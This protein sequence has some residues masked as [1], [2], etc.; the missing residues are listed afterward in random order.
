MIAFTL[1]F[2]CN[3]PNSELKSERKISAK[4]V[5]VTKIS[6]IVAKSGEVVH[7]YG[8]NFDTSSRLYRF[9]IPLM[10]GSQKLVRIAVNDSSTASFTMPDGVGLG[11]KTVDFQNNSETISSFN[12]IA[13]Q[14]ANTL[15]IIID[16]ANEICS[17]RKYIDRDGNTSTGTKDCANGSI[18]DC[19]TDGETGCKTTET[20]K[21]ANSSVA[22]AANIKAGVTIGG[23]PGGLTECSSDGAIGCIT[24]ASFKAVDMTNVVV[25]N[26]KTSVNLAGVVG[27]FNGDFLP[28]TVDGQIGCITT[29]SY[30]AADVAVAIAGNIKTGITLAG[31]AGSVTPSPA[32]CTSAGQQSCVATGTYY[33]GTQ[34]VANSSAC[35]L[36][37]YVSTTQ[38]LKA[39]D[40]D[41]IDTNASKIRSGTTL[42]GVSGSLADCSTDGGTGC[43]ATASFKAA[44]VAVAIAGNIK[45]G[46]TLAGQTGSVIPS[47]VNCASAGQQS[48]VATGTYYAG[49]QCVAN[50]SACYLPSYVSSTQPLKA[51]DY[52]NI[53]SNATKVRSGTTLGGVAGLL[54]DC[55]TDG[56]I[57]C[58]T[59]ASFTAADMTNVTPGN[60]KSGVTIAAIT[61]QYPSATFALSG[62]DVTADLDAATFDAKIKS[63][64]SFEYWDSS[65]T[66]HTGAGDADIIA[67][68]ISNG[69]DV[70]GATGTLTGGA[71]PNS[72]DIRKGVVVNGVTGNL[73][74]NC[75]NRSR[76]AVYNYDGVVSSIPNT[77][78]T[79]GTTL[80]YWDSIE[81]WNSGASGLP[82]SVITGWTNSDC[83]G[84][85]ASEGDANVWKDVTTAG[86]GAGNCTDSPENCTM[87]DKISGLQWSKL[88]SYSSTWSQ[89]INDCD[90][91]TH[92]GDSDWRLPTQKELMEAYNHG[93]RSAASDN[94]VAE[95]AMTSNYFWS[96]TSSSANRSLAWYLSFAYGMTN[97]SNKASS[98][99][100]VACVR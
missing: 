14:S 3:M 79:T 92:N 96:A 22:V 33:A 71:T 78:V 31:Q 27:T 37:S 54:A 88:V 85:E 18:A 68:N 38:P 95:G 15:P 16:D 10:D 6:P 86:V 29:A 87:K 64:T 48:C 52:D 63:A 49:T 56:G 91:L 65:G 89:A 40:Y 62:A 90:A 4:K 21:A 80:N 83:G 59:T 60:I 7:V 13:D 98:N 45:T 43:V 36:A 66:R 53:D 30:K 51:I 46:I 17:T 44:D 84:V 47:P 1:L 69:V 93:I 67:A 32:N 100:Y 55:S 12:L 9:S 94:W 23:V 20:F 24:T 25:G 70:F 73:Y 81:D 2:S 99:Y 28:C 76:D 19:K 39:I 8:D 82:S 41:N 58:V 97:G 61:G 34:C 26:I 77:G 35:Y 75:R 11:L 72:W 42:G 57:G 74:A 5:I 50:S